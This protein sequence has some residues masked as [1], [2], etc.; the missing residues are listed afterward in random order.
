[1][2]I[3]GRKL[4]C[5][6]AKTVLILNGFYDGGGVE[7]ENRRDRDSRRRMYKNG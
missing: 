5:V 1:M 4:R 6:R 7:Y 2:H 3:K